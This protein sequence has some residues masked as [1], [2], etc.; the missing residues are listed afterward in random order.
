[1]VIDDESVGFE[2]HY[3]T[4]ELAPLEE[5]ER[6]PSGADQA[7]SKLDEAIKSNGFRV[8][9]IQDEEILRRS[10]EIL[11]VTSAVFSDHLHTWQIARRVSVESEIRPKAL[12][13]LRRGRIGSSKWVDSAKHKNA[14]N[15]Y[16]QAG[17]PKHQAD[18][19]VQELLNDPSF[20]VELANVKVAHER[21]RSR[22]DDY[23]RHRAKKNSYSDKQFTEMLHFVED[24]RIP[25]ELARNFLR[26]YLDRK[27]AKRAKGFL[28]LF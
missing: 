26:S 14:L 20:G 6:A 8:L 4:S 10:L 22:V 2:L 1:L 12:E 25:E 19:K 28:G 13:W 15:L 3:K 16:T 9:T 21:W 17:F 18:S 7:Y 5:K 27:G 23:L 24:L 11:G